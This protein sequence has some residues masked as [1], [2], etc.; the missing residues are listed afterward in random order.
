[1]KP[2]MTV[3]FKQAQQ[4]LT[5]VELMVAMLI[6]VILMAGV[7]SIMISSKRAYNVQNDLNH[8]QENARFAMGFLVKDL[9]M[10]GYFGCQGASLSDVLP[11]QGVE[12]TGES[13]NNSDMIRVASIE[14]NLNAF[15]IMHCPPVSPPLRPLPP[16]TSE[17]EY[18]L[19]CPG[20]AEAGYP[21]VSPLAFGEQT[22]NLTTINFNIPGELEQGDT[23]IAADCGSADRYTIGSIVK[24]GSKTSSLTLDRPLVRSYDNAGYSYGAELRRL[25]EYRY[26]IGRLITQDPDT[27]R[28][29]ESFALCRDEENFNAALRC[30]PNGSPT[31]PN[32]AEVLIEGVE[33]LQIRYG[34]KSGSA[35]DP[36]LQY[37][38]A[39]ALTQNDWI[40]NVKSV[41]ISLLMRTSIERFDQ[42]IDEKTY[43]LDPDLDAFGPLND[44]RLRKTFINTIMLRN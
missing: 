33:N 38:K 21:S 39:D 27:G 2:F 23:L 12:D 30:D 6:G 7:L 44:H 14:T 32:S 25:R 24:T 5:L 22:F 15:A 13:V 37:L 18:N 8:L 19:A 20:I 9:R 1:M 28:E 11:V 40:N 4:G 3:Q 29:I 34:L 43:N 42:D 17:A 31:P 26:F 36:T 10:A 35:T 16:N 41:R